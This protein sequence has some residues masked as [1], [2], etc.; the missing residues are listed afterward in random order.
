MNKLKNKLQQLVNEYVRKRD[1]HNG[2]ARCISCGKIMKAGTFHAGHYYAAGKYEN[3]RFDLD[4]IHAQCVQCNYYEHGN[5]IQY[6]ENLIAKIGLE[7]V[8]KLDMKAAYY[9]RHGHKWDDFTLN[10]MIQDIKEK[11]NGQQ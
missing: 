8:K 4:N 10:I 3:L 7:R 6:R 11:L 9:R 2:Y 1:T 5:L